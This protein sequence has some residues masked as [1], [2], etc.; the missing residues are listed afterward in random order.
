MDVITDKI[1]EDCR[2]VLKLLE[3]HCRALEETEQ[4]ALQTNAEEIKKLL[5]E[6]FIRWIHE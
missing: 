3:I 5:Y 2:G 1:V 6:I 4:W